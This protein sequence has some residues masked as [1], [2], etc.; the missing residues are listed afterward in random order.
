MKQQI[1]TFESYLITSRP[2]A[3][4]YVKTHIPPIGSILEAGIKRNVHLSNTAK[5]LSTRSMPGTGKI[6]NQTT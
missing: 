2:M 1:T 4:T 6:P 3:F 5:I